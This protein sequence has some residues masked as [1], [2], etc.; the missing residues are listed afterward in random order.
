MAGN[1][2]D[3]RPLPSVAAQ[4]SLLKLSDDQRECRYDAVM[5]CGSQWQMRLSK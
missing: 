5:L 3:V 1:V 4:Q 2:W